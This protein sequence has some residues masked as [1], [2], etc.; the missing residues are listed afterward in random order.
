MKVKVGRFRFRCS[1]K[2]AP[3]RLLFRPLLLLLPPS[4]LPSL[5]VSLSRSRHIITRVQRARNPTIARIGSGFARMT[6]FGRRERREEGG[7]GGG[8]PRSGGIGAARG[9]LNAEEKRR[10]VA[11]HKMRRL[12]R[13]RRRRRRRWTR[14]GGVADRAR[15]G[16]RV[17]A[18]KNAARNCCNVAT[19]EFRKL[20][21]AV[22]GLWPRRV[23]AF[24]SN[25]DR[26][27]SVKLSSVKI[28]GE[29]GRAR[30]GGLGNSLLRKWNVR[31]T[32][33]AWKKERGGGDLLYS[34][35]PISSRYFFAC[36]KYL[37]ARPKIPFSFPFF[38]FVKIS[39]PC[40]PL[41][42]PKF[43]LF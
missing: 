40:F 25:V 20:G 36:Q 12:T 30:E 9:R 37:C 42:V 4:I 26:D 10:I 5:P 39:N 13:R 2:A 1:A 3:P 35:C 6:R 14:G 24:V 19:A 7:G 41:R 11:R 16:G 33:L 21:R 17:L 31:S 38:E 22:P 43:F 18:S 23:A 15:G 28:R 8:G 27:S 34:S 32:R 29:R